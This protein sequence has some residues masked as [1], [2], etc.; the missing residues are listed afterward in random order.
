LVWRLLTARAVIEFWQKE[1]AVAQLRLA[2]QEAQREGAFDLVQVTLGEIAPVLDA[3]RTV[4]A[5]FLFDVY[6]RQVDRE[7]ANAPTPRHRVMWRI[8]AAKAHRWERRWYSRADTVACVTA[9]D[10]EAINPVLP[11]PARVVPVPLADEFFEEPPR[12]RSSD[13]VAII[14]MLNYRPNIDALLWFTSEVW[15]RVIE[16]YPGARLQVVGRAPVDDVRTAVADVGGDLHADVPDAR[17]YYWSAG[18]V[19]VPMR[20]GSG[21]RNKVLHAIATGAPLV[22]TSTAIEGIGLED[23]EHLLVADEGADD[24]AA[25]VVQC[26]AD[27][28]GALRRAESARRFCERYRIG[29]V[30][31]IHDQWWHSAAGLG[32]TV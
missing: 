6:G 9:L 32:T 30:A 18:V 20:L 17:P 13:T 12:R 19:P 10:A 27:R 29:H 11:N 25:K 31:A 1:D 14:G 3:V 23:E 15:P 26:L 8:E 2:V 22:A 21:M 5:L 28:E 4:S 24:F 7:V 16:R